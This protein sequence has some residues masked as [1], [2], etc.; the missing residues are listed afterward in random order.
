MRIKQ[1][2][3]RQHTIFSGCTKIAIAAMLFITLASYSLQASAEWLSICQ[4]PVA[5][6][7]DSNEYLAFMLTPQENTKVLSLTKQPIADVACLQH[8]VPIPLENVVWAG[9]A[10]GLDGKVEHIALLGTLQETRF[11][12]SEIILQDQENPLAKTTVQAPR[13]PALARAKNGIVRSVWF[14]SPTAWLTTP[15]RI[16][17]TQ[18]QFKL[19][20]VYI[21]IPIEKDTVSHLRE[22]K[23]FIKSAH[24]KNLQVWTVMGDPHAI[25]DSER[26]NY[27]SMA[28]VYGQFNDDAKE[29]ERLDGLQLD[30]EP[31]LLP[32]YRYAVA[33]MMDKY[34][35]VIN[36]IHQ[37]APALALDAVLPFWFNLDEP[38]MANALVQISDSISSLTVMDYRTD[39]EQIRTFA[40]K[41][42]NWGDL[43]QKSVHIALESLAMQQEVMRFYQRSD[44]GELVEVNFGE[45]YGDEVRVLLLLKQSLSNQNKL[46]SYQYSHSQAVDGNNTSFYGHQDKLM[47]LLPQLENEFTRSPSFAGISLHGLD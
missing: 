28:A 23:A 9:F 5:Q 25:L 6:K 32:G 30:I 17:N 22:L 33:E 37:G 39:T 38:I 10:P 34:A 15:E 20:R 26:G 41:F 45:K 42:F 43:H 46:P 7:V 8:E 16:F 18:K 35:D 1:F 36:I 21:S 24:K 11:K 2:Y 19:N 4:R 13:L 14:W 47:Q 31:Y 29:A 12:V 44:K 40:R 27:L 3:S